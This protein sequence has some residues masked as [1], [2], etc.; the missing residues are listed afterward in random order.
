MDLERELLENSS[1]IYQSQNADK[2]AFTISHLRV[3]FFSVPS[4]LL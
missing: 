4:R 2:Q 3:Y 1:L